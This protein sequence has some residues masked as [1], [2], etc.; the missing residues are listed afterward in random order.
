MAI[1]ISKEDLIKSVS[2]IPASV[3]TP[4]TDSFS[5]VLDLLNNPAIQQILLRI[6]NR[7]MPEPQVTNPQTLQM[8]QPQSQSQSQLDGNTIYD[9]VMGFLDTY[10][11]AN[12]TMTVKELKEELTKNKEKVVSVINSYLKK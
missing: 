11:V 2:S 7:F 6:F 4:T 12:P 3:P 5:K 1:A 8:A 10:T 9:G